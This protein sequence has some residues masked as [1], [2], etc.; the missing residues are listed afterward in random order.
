MK[1][2]AFRLQS[3]LN[4]R[5]K[6][7]HQ[8]HLVF[9]RVLQVVQTQERELVDLYRLTSE[10][11]EELREQVAEKVDVAALRQERLYLA[12]VTRRIAEAIKRLR[13]VENEL[14]HARRRLID[15][16]RDRRALEL[17]H[18]RRGDEYEYEAN[19]QMQMELD[20]IGGRSWRAKRSAG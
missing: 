3:V 12:S 10:A 19:R 4:Y 17:L 1:K 6:I 20:E 14:E 11:I 8:R 7:E 15:A 9:A 5:E 2:F 13:T 16:R 18:Q